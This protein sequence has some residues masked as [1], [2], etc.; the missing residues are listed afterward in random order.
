MYMENIDIN[1]EYMGEQHK[2]WKLENVFKH[3]SCLDPQLKITAR[4]LLL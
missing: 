2:Y 3:K 4:L 1:I